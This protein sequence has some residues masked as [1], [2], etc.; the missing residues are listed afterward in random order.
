MKSLKNKYP[1]YPKIQYNVDNQLQK[2]RKLKSE[3]SMDQM[4]SRFSYLSE[5]TNL[6]NKI[7][8]T[9]KIPTTLEESIT[10]PIF[11]KII[12]MDF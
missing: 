2:I 5:L 11:K 3:N 6:L 1:I 10:I 8:E 7:F 9:E 12:R 4:V